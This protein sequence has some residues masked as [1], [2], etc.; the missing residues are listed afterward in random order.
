MDRMY[1]K[2]LVKGKKKGRSSRKVKQTVKIVDTEVSPQ[3]PQVTPETHYIPSL[4][5]RSVINLCS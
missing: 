1:N 4:S 5:F 3:A 2:K